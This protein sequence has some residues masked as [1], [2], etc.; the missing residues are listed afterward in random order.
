MEVTSSSKT[1]WQVW[2]ILLILTLFM[3]FFE[4]IEAPA[5]VTIIVL[6]SA[7][8]IKATLIGGWFMHLRKESRFLTIVLVAATLLTIAFLFFLLIPD[9]LAVSARHQVILP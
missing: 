8:M 4:A 2:G 7:M 5:A 3:I 9:A 6:A 1:Y